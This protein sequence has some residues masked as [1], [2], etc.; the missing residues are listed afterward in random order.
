MGNCVTVAGFAFNFIYL[1]FLLE[2]GLAVSQ[3][4]LWLAWNFMCSRPGLLQPEMYLPGAEQER[5][6]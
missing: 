2:Q 3:R 5:W 4:G 1:L 6:D